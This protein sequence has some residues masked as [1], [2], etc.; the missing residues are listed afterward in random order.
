MTDVMTK[1]ECELIK[2]VFKVGGGR[3]FLVND[4]IITAAHCLPKD[5]P[6][7]L[8][9]APEDYPVIVESLDGSRKAFMYPVFVEPISDIT[10]LRPFDDDYQNWCDLIAG[11][12]GFELAWP[13]P[14][15]SASKVLSLTAEE[16]LPF[17]AQVHPRCL[18][19]D[20][21]YERIVPG[22]SGSPVMTPDN[23]VV[24]LISMSDAE[25]AILPN[26]TPWVA[27]LLG[28]PDF[29]SEAA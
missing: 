16:W 26:I 8:C 14:C 21:E 23:K 15:M 13:E 29:G 5:L 22:M 10:V 6:I 12:M 27:R 25:A 9:L 17:D 11:Q 3:G 18:R 19:L 4:C 2:S 7:A 1:P 28:V 24:G 20:H